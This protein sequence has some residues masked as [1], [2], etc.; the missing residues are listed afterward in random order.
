MRYWLKFVIEGELHTSSL[1][2]E[3]ISEVT[4]FHL[5]SSARIFHAIAF[6]KIEKNVSS[7]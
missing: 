5:P 2:V 7:Y 4:H 6:L 1:K 3:G